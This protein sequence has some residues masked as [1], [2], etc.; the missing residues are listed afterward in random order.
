MLIAAISILAM[1]SAMLPPLHCSGKNVVDPQ[2]KIVQM[3]GVNL[4]GWFVDEIWMTPWLK[5]PE[6][7]KPDVIKDHKTLW[8]SIESRLGAASMHLVREAW[9]ANWISAED[10][11]RI[12]AAGFDHV[13]IPFLDSLFE[14]DDGIRILR[15]AVAKAKQSG[16]YVVLDLHGAPGGQSTEHHTG[17]EGRNRLWFDVDNI[18]KMEKLWIRIAKEFAEEPAVAMF[19]IMN[20]PVGAPNA[21]M[22]HLVY[23]RVIR[24]I[25]TVAPRKIVLVDDGY[26]GFET[27]PHPNIAN[28]QNVAFSLHFYQFNSKT[29]EE[30]VTN[31]KSRMPKLIELQ[32]YRNA[33]VYA[34]E[35]NLEPFNSPV[36]MSLFVA[37]FLKAG[38]SYALWTWKAVPSSGALGDWGLYRPNGAVVPLDPFHDSEQTLIAK[39]RAVRT[40]NLVAPPTQVAAAAGH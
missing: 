40:E 32:G 31:L 13:R 23:D 33:P 21:S 12:R 6:V 26:K 1:R 15:E 30:H 7:G 38:W 5:A 24:A 18:E 10:F 9:R 36:S 8:A 3:R 35:F 25:R 20:E 14:E 16:L 19:D 28:W 11:T 4:G 39:M 37:E 27:T 29:T 17:S 2:G 22:L 34:G